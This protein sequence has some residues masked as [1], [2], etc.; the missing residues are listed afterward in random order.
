MSG[1]NQLKNEPLSYK[2]HKFIR[3]YESEANNGGKVCKTYKK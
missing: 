2:I 1:K 3:F